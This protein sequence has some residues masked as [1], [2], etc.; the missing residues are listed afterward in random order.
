MT[1]GSDVDTM[2][3]VRGRLFHAIRLWVGRALS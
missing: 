3:P 1:L 2:V